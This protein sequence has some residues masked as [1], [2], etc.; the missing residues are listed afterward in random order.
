MKYTYIAVLHPEE[1]G[2]LVKFPDIPNCFTDGEDLQD[3][4]DM[5]KDVLALVLWQMEEDKKEIPTPTPADKIPHEVAD[6]LAVIEAD[7]VAYRKENDNKAVPRTLSL[8]HWM[9]VKAK[10]LS[11]S[12]SSV[13]QKALLKEFETA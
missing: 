9:D 7:T 1:G 8:P 12:L 10:E 5:A 3:A 11:L 4:I 13:L 2:Y 6:V